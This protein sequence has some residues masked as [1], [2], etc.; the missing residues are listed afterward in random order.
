MSLLEWVPALSNFPEGQQCSPRCSW[1]PTQLLVLPVSL[2]A[3]KIAMK[4]ACNA[5]NALADQLSFSEKHGNGIKMCFPLLQNISSKCLKNSSQL[6]Q[7]LIVSLLNRISQLKRVSHSGQWHILFK[8]FP[9]LLIKAVPQEKF[10]RENRD[11]LAF[12][13]SKFSC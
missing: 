12:L 3:P 1:T 8:K 2:P 7:I 11:K 9:E 6:L 5:F 4:L 13:F 10:V